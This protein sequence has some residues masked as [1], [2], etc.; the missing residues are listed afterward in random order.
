M[1][2]S[3]GKVSI[4]VKVDDKEVMKLE[5][6]LDGVQ[7]KGTDTETSLTKLED[8]VKKIGSSSTVDKLSSDLGVVGSE[9]TK[10]SDGLNKVSDASKAIT[11]DNVDKLGSKMSNTSKDGEGLSES[12]KR[13]QEREKQVRSEN[14]D[15]LRTKMNESEESSKKLDLGIGNVV[16]SV[17]LLALAS[18]ALSV[19]SSSMDAAIS[20]FDTFKTYPKVMNSLGFSTD[21]ATA[22]V[23]TLSKG[24]DGLPTKLDD[25]VSTSKRMTSVTGNLERSTQATL[26]LNNAMLASG[27]STADAN[28][29]MEQYIQMLS[30]GKVDMM[31]WRT[32]QET[33]PIGLQ[34]TAEAM[35][36]VGETAQSSLYAALQQGDITFKQF[37]A[38]L[39]E[40]GTGTGE[41][42]ELAKVN[43]EG[44]ATSLS[45]LRNAATR[46][47]ADILDSFNTLIED[48]T[49]KSLAKNIDGLKAI[50]NASFKA[51][52]KAI[53]LTTP[54]VKLFVQILI[55]LISVGKT[56]SPVLLGLVAAYTAFT[57]LSKINAAWK[58]QVELFT[59]AK[60]ATEGLTLATTAQMTAQKLSTDAT[61]ADVIVSAASN[62]AIKLKTFLVGV[63]SG[64]ITI[65]TAAQ[66]AM[67]A[68]TAAFNTVISVLSGPIGWVTLALGA[69]VAVGTAV[70]KI[71]K[72]QTLNGE[73]LTK[74]TEDLAAS[75]EKLNESSK[76]NAITRKEDIDSMKAHTSATE[77]SI[78][79][80][81]NLVG[82]QK[83]TN[84]ERKMM[85]ETIENLNE[86]FADLNLEYNKESNSLNMSTEEI[87]KRTQALGNQDVAIEAQRQLTE[88]TK[89]QVEAES[90]L[91]ELTAQRENWNKKLEDG[92]VKGWEAKEAFKELDEQEKALNET[93]YQLAIEHDNAQKVMTESA[94]LADE[95]LNN[96]IENQ[97]ISYETLSET[98]QKVVDSMNSKWQEYANSATDMFN[99]LSEE[100]TIS[101]QEMI[102]NMEENQRIIGQWAENIALLTKRGVDEGIIEKLREAGP[103]S[104]GHVAALVN[105][106]DEELAKLNSV[107]SQGATTATKAMENSLDLGSAGVEDKI[108]SMMTRTKT[109]LK[110]E[111]LAANFG[112]LGGNIPEG[113]G[114]GIGKN[115]KVAEKASEDMAIRVEDAF[116]HH[117]AIKSPSRVFMSHGGYLM[118]GLANGINQSGNNPIIQ[119]IQVATKI[120]TS[121]NFLPDALS[122]VGS[123]AAIG[124]SNGLYN[125]AESAYSAARNIA[126]NIQN[127]MQS[128]FDI[129]SPSRWMRDKIGKFIPQGIAVGII[130]DAPKAFKA[131][132]RLNQG[133]KLVSTPEMALDF[134]TATNR[135]DVK[136]QTYTRTENIISKNNDEV[137]LLRQQNELLTRI[138]R[139]DNNVYVDSEDMTQRV[140]YNNALDDKLRYF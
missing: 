58:T 73:K 66:V 71:W 56:L 140:N 51:M 18:K 14:I 57:V 136:P 120:V 94:Q 2:E 101:T 13:V 104:A 68:A 88:I 16:K 121:T 91:E 138:L 105:S 70:V 90:K 42:A 53:E 132:E 50:V 31:S 80:I 26:A 28:R 74:Q 126:R 139:K 118:Q 38:Q 52:G 122:R 25:V 61:K 111:I 125:G 36:Y 98:Q 63:L 8:A 124:L 45:N 112:N 49:G 65:A 22:S 135:F 102:S 114:D 129:H 137:V 99:T 123:N 11:S 4:N 97:I 67:T 115:S 113:L 78:D 86:N 3:D 87:K 48:V 15:Q 134:G 128:A 10:A 39:I 43:S 83:L 44:I 7:K 107:F 6:S 95:A 37:Q 62:G 24:I 35:G 29:G 130:A 100:Q 75:S 82:K 133:M 96:I 106:S 60:M 41:L 59:I 46:G 72:T 34:K 110:D 108:R 54:I 33:M 19:L 92:I 12:M 23:D 17:G 116:T 27:A 103:T 127:I 79:A 9:G 30:T 40:L 69:L 81:G 20:R 47:I 76:N 1:A 85:N 64:K 77:A 119:M 93:V 109:T 32:L 89:E 55:E 131:I 21:E 5:S 117:M 84:T